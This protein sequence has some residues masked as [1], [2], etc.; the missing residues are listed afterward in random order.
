M[1]ITYLGLS[2]FR[3]KGKA[4]TLVTDPF[5]SA[6]VGFKFPKT[7]AE[8]VTLSHQHEDHSF[9]SGIEGSPFVVSSPGEYEVKDVSLFGYPST[10]NTASNNELGENIIYLIEMDGFRLCHLGDLG[11]IP[12]TKV[13]EEIIGV[14]VL[15]VP[16]GGVVTLD[17][18]KAGE[19]ISQIEPL[20]V[21]PMHYKTPGINEEV[22]GKMASI[23]DFLKEMGAETAEHLDKLSLNKDKLPQETK[24]IVLE[25]K[26]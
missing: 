11:T 13:M 1:D 25:R 22:Y 21:L 16:V 19:I 6:M 18:E 23:E 26:G 3:L 4:V 7:E 12:S 2:A 10:H 9:V 8:I 17:P 5:S 15:M 14:D 24:V 20:I